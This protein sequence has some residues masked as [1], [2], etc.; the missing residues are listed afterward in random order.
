MTTAAEDPDLKHLL[1]L[2][3]MLPGPEYHEFWTAVQH[4]ILPDTNLGYVYE[5]MTGIWRV[6]QDPSHGNII[7]L[8][9]YLMFFFAGN[10]PELWKILNQIFHNQLSLRHDEAGRWWATDVSKT[11]WALYVRYSHPSDEQWT[12]KWRYED[13]WHEWM[14]PPD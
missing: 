13:T 10:S 14:R 4:R 7:H 11:A 12:A 9:R 1:E 3:S 6:I 5:K 8:A 2:L